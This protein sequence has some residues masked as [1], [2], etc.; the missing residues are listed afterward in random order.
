M[1]DH[2]HGQRYLCVLPK[3]NQHDLRQKTAQK[4]SQKFQ[5]SACKYISVVLLLNTPLMKAK[6]N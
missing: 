6:Q 3:K 5:N 1:I 2:Q 4:S